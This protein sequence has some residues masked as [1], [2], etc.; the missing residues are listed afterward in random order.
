MRIFYNEFTRAAGDFVGI[1]L[2]DKLRR[3]RLLVGGCGSIGSRVVTTGVRS[4]KEN[5]TF[6]GSDVVDQSKS[7]SP[8]LYI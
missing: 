2:Q 8:G 6:A 5:I 3:I 1:E 4:G 7:C